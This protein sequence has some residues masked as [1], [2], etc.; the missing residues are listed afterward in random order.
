WCKGHFPTIA[1]VGRLAPGPRMY[2]HS[3]GL[4]GGLQS[5]RTAQSTR[6]D[7]CC[8]APGR[9]K[10]LHPSSPQPPS[11][12]KISFEGIIADV[13]SNCQQFRFV[14]NNMIV[15]M[16]LPELV[17]ADITNCSEVAESGPGC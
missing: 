11:L 13:F 5:T 17:S 16:L 8:R 12:Q 7:G 2:F 15:K 6:H 9:R 3:R 14:A 10:R 4:N 1:L